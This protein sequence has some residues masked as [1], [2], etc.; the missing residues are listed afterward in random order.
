MC[1]FLSN[2]SDSFSL[3]C[4]SVIT[5]TTMVIVDYDPPVS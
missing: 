3:Y 4:I 2:V 5:R 1:N